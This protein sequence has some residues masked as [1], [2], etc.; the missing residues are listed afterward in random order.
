MR[1][2]RIILSSNGLLTYYLMCGASSTKSRDIARPSVFSATLR[3]VFEICLPV[4]ALPFVTG[5][6]VL[7][8]N[9]ELTRAFGTLRFSAVCGPHKLPDAWVRPSR[10]RPLPIEAEARPR[11][12]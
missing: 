1:G 12:K 7:L 4:R 9:P 11:T 5:R 6:Q 2:S 8:F 10:P 3:R